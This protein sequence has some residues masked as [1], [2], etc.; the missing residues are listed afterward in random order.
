VPLYLRLLGRPRVEASGQ[1]NAWPP[2]RPYRLLALLAMRRGWVGR[3]E[4]AALFWSDMNRARSAANVRK[5]LHLARALP[6][7]DAL[8]VQGAAV[9]WIVSTDVHDL[10]LA[11]REGRAA[12][13]LGLAA[14]GELLDGMDDAANGAWTEWLAGERALQR[15][16]VQALMHAR[17]AAGADA[18][19]EVVELAGRL[20]DVDPL[21]EDAVVALLVALGALKRGNEQRAA[22]R[23]YALRLEDELGVEPSQRVRRLLPDAAAAAAAHDETAHDGLFGRANDLEALRTL[24]AR[25]DCRLLTI[26]GPGG[27]GK[28]SLAKRVLR[29]LQ[30]SFAD[31]VHW[32][33]L[34]DLQQMAQVV[35]RLAAELKLAPAPQ[36]QPLVLVGEH[37]AAL[38]VLL[39]FDNAEHLPELPRLIERLLG[40]APRLRVCATSRVRLA[41]RG[42]WLL[43][44][45]GLALP[46]AQAAA[47]AVLASPAA[48]LFI[49]A[50]Q[51]ARPDFDAAREAPAIGALL[52]ACGG[53]PL[54]ILLAANWVRL[55][56]VA[57]I[58]AELTR[59]LDVLE[60]ADDGEERPEHRS[61]RATF[62]QSWHRLTEREQRSLSALSVFA[63]SFSRQAAQEVAGAALPLLAALADRSLLQLEAGGRCSLHPLI[64][65]FARERLDAQ[66]L[67]AVQAQHARHFQ[68]RLAHLER[69]AIAADQ[70]ALD[71]IGLDLEN[72]RQAWRW[73]VAQRATDV[74]A[75]TAVALK[76]Y[77][78]V[79]GR[80]AEGLELL[81]EAR[82]LAD[83]DA[84][85]GAIVLSAI[86]QSH[87]RLSRLDDAAAAARQGIR[88][89]RAAGSRAA[90]VRCLSV[91]GTCCWQWGRNDEAR[92]LL[93]QAVRHAEAIGDVRGAALAIHNLALV[94]KALGNNARAAQ[95]MVDWLV[96]Q[97]AQGEW[98]RV[99]MGLSNLA[100]V[101][102]AQGEWH[103]AQ[104]CLEEG[105]ALC[106]AHD[107]AL[108]RP[109]LLANLAHNHAMSGKL[110][111][112]EHVSRELATE[113]RRMGLADVEAT[114]L[115]QL[116]RV[117]ILRGD[118]GLARARLS[119][120]VGR[121]VPLS[122]EYIR[123]DCV[124]SY[125]KILSGE[126]NAGAAVPLLR[127]LLDRSDLEPVDRA[128]AEACLRALP[129]ASQGAAAID[130][131]FDQLLQ[132]IAAE[133][134]PQAP[135]GAR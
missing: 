71:E 78:N 127:R 94:E 25:D 103:L 111:Q 84:P 113:A 2:E 31:G 9:R 23:S 100:Y 58:H 27:V 65:Q 10:E 18:P 88:L 98:L 124:L 28:S 3:A 82:A 105:L 37:L 69:A 132:R 79:R 34:D 64:R 11:A 72:C 87:Y 19:A 81:S 32:I 93:Q 117:A 67:A 126:R 104:A 50:A 5:A 106:D 4:L 41:V 121:A 85:C 102:Q 116:V 131:P 115:N 96:V 99:A 83:A 73:A 42:E 125:A 59:S 36:Q 1:S 74:L 119:D 134:A 101:Y 46:S 109:A 133:L 21:D 55:L 43:P 54:A 122:I 15:R 112:A 56:S 12:D 33:A 47:D 39:V 48:Q 91:L 61:V 8:E 40:G 70:A 123:I 129:A 92:R 60:A 89:A 68:H 95:L 7:A 108:P 30:A 75:A 38:D 44:L 16:R 62:G 6:W 63:G 13:A 52:H 107:L 86:A 97:R 77:F 135:V 114:A 17:L 80:V 76:E 90:S 57:E 130:V 49:A 118:L 51:D 20:L 53:L 22:Y 35:A 14:A 26:T 128:D 110:D 29:R 45:Q 66:A 24:L 120:A